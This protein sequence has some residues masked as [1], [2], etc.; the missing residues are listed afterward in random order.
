MTDLFDFDAD[1]DIEQPG[2]QDETGDQPAATGDLEKWAEDQLADDS[3]PLFFDIETGPAPEEQLAELYHEKTLEEFSAT[4]DKRWKP[5][6]VAK[7]YEEY[8]T[9][10]W[11]NFVGKAALSAITGR[12]LMVGMLQDWEFAG[13]MDD[14]ERATLKAFWEVTANALDAKR[15]LIGHNSNGFDLPF[16]VRRSWMLG[17]H[18]PRE[19][20]HG[21][22]WNPLFVDT[23]EAWGCGSRDFIRLNDLGQCFGVGQKTEGFAGKDFHKFWFGTPEERQLAIDYCEQDVRLTAAIAGKMGLV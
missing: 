13:I 23:M 2:G 10:A 1:L 9:G 11:E 19:V 6:T 15:R 18:V 7:K 12:V 4:C 16:L 5:D 8:K 20:K 22:Y 17:V 14:Y 3:A 21:R